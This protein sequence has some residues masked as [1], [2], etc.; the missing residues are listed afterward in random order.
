MTGPEIKSL[1]HRINQIYLDISDSQEELEELEGIL[2]AALENPD[3]P[4]V[5]LG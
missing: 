1:E 4:A 5:V 2:K 3:M